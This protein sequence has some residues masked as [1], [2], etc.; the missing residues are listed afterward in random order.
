MPQQYGP[1]SNQVILVVKS[2]E[3]A[4]VANK[5]PIWRSVAKLMKM[6]KR[7]KPTMNIEKVAKLVKEGQTVLVPVR[8]LSLGEVPDFAFTIAVASASVPARA[9]F[10]G[11]KAKL[12]S[13]LQLLEANPKGSGVRIIV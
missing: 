2:L 1:E 7:K 3:H 6:P 12:V 5:A 4:A 13:I 8:L 10:A 11:K 9:K